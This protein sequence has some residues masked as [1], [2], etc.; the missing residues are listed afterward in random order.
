[1]ADEPTPPPP[2]APPAEP[3]APPAGPDLEAAVRTVLHKMFG[4]TPPQA[5]PEPVES[6]KPR[7]QGDITE[8]M[9]AKA[10]EALDRVF[11]NRAHEEEHEK[12]RQ[13]PPVAPPEKP[14]RLRKALWGGRE[15]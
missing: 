12:L 1:M 9:E 4:D 14:N 8:W 10:T 3:P 7:T 13:P 15:P 11:K 2:P 6:K 5:P